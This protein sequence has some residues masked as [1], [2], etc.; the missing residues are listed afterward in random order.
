MTE[1]PLS[2]DQTA[3]LR[4]GAKQFTTLINF[5]YLLLAGVNRKKVKKMI[6]QIHDGGPRPTLTTVP[7]RAHDVSNT[8]TERTTLTRLYRITTPQAIWKI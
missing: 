2:A 6:R 1:F 7:S 8:H 5:F 3:R 4:L